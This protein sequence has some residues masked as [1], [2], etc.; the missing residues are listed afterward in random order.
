[1]PTLEKERSSIAAR[2]REL[3]RGRRWTQAELSARLG[4]SQ[5]RL[6][7]I[8]RGA[9]SFTAE[10]F[11]LILKLFNATVSDF[12]VAVRDVDAE[13]Q[14]ALARLGALH[15][16]ES[17]D[18]LPSAQIESVGEALREGLAA[19]SPRLITA[20]APVLV[21]NVNRVNLKKLRAEL[22]E[23]GL[24]RRLDWLVDNTIDALRNE[25]AHGKAPRPWTQRYRRALLVLETFLDFVRPP[26][27]AGSSPREAYAPDILD[28]HIR[29]KE[30]LKEVATSSSP[31]SQRWG[32]VTTLQPEDFVSALKAARAR[33]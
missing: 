22:T 1:M 33:G 30:T 3:R 29:S 15:L 6:S 26:A 5:A 24:E 4:L 12:T 9:G 18:V 11:L 21:L 7:E 20:L 13:I 17:S 31:S 16:H 25:L 32:I 2:V 23:A 27:R 8:E 28:A 10:Q 14:N 19:G